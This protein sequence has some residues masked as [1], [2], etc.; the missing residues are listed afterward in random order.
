MP[1]AA[2]YRGPPR[3]ERVDE[4]RPRDIRQERVEADVRLERRLRE[5]DHSEASAP[6]LGFIGVVEEHETAGAQLGIVAVPARDDVCRECDRER[7]ERTRC[8]DLRNAQFRSQSGRTQGVECGLE[9]G[10]LMRRG[11]GHVCR[12]ESRVE[13]TL[14]ARR[15]V[16][17]TGS[18][19]EEGTHEST[20]G[21][22]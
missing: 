12:L 5:A 16:A 21:S 8:R 3:I 10:W 20:S 7:G 11:V 17:H 13:G 15:T 14:A 6:G 1:D 9:L 2:I 18:L 4:P 22:P 19:R